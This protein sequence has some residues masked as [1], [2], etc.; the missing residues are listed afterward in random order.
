LKK[1]LRESDLITRC[2]GEEFYIILSLTSSE[3][4]YDIAEGLREKIAVL[5]KYSNKT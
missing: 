1:Q 4:A 2:G 5:K 3:K